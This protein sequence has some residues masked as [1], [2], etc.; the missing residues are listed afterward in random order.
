MRKERTAAFFC[1]YAGAWVL[2]W[3]LIGTLVA[4]YVLVLLC[5]NHT[6]AMGGLSVWCHQDPARSMWWHGAP[7]AL[8]ARCTGIYPGFLVGSLFAW[9]RQ[10]RIVLAI[11]LVLTG[12]ADRAVFM[13]TGCDSSN[14][15]RL[16][17]GVSLGVGASGFLWTL[18]RLLVRRAVSLGFWRHLAFMIYGDHVGDDAAKDPE[19]RSTQQRQTDASV[20]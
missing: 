9:T 10:P 6:Q 3:A 18:G 20:D 16:L 1:G 12:I 2:G 15:V 4:G 13:A 17:L 8:C 14:S 5:A 11:T 7:L 19:T